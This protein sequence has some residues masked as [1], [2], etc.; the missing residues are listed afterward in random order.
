LLFT[1]KKKKIAT[2]KF[3]DIVSSHQ[4]QHIT[5][6]MSL[7]EEQSIQVELFKKKKFKETFINNGKMWKELFNENKPA[8]TGNGFVFGRFWVAVLRPAWQVLQGN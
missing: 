8:N 5:T 3:G 7:F 4:N 1:T 2:V 6:I